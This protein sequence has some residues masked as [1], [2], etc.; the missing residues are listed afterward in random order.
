MN[1][2]VKNE[3]TRLTESPDFEAKRRKRLGQ[4]FTGPRLARLLVAIAEGSRADSAI[5]PMSGS[6]DMLA[7]VNAVAP[8]AH[9]AGIEID[10]SAYDLSCKRLNAVTGSLELFEGDAFNWSTIAQLSRFSFDLVATNPPYVRYQTLVGGSLAASDHS[11]QSRSK[12][13]RNGLLEICNHLPDLTDRDRKIFSSLIRG[14]SGLSDLAVPSW[15]LCAM[16]TRVGG[17]LAVIVPHQWLS[18]EYAYIV[19]YLLLKFFNIQ[20]V[21]EDAH[22]VWFEEA[23]VKTSLVVAERV[24]CSLDIVATCKG[25]FYLDVSLPASASTPGSEVG[26][27]FPR[28]QH[29][30][31][32][33]AEHLKRLRAHDEANAAD[34]FS[35]TRRSLAHKLKD[36]LQRCGHQKWFAECEST[37]PGATLG[38]NSAT[39]QARVPQPL[40]DL[41]P[42]P[43]DP[44]ITLEVLNVSVGQGLRTGANDFFYCELLCENKDEHLI[45]PS[46]SFGLEPLWVPKAV[47]R[48]VLRRQSELSGAYSVSLE[49]LK[50][51]VLVLDQFI[52]PHD[53]AKLEG[54]GSFLSDNHRLNVMSP[55]LAQLVSTAAGTNV[56]SPSEPKFIPEMSAV[57]TN[58]TK[59]DNSGKARFWYMLPRFARRHLPDLLIPRVNYRHPKAVIN[60][61][62]RV[63]VDANFSTL[64]LNEG[65]TI[66]PHALL[67]FLES[68]WTIAAMELSA[69][70]LGGGAL[71][72]E[73]AHIR[74]LP[75]PD[76]SANDWSLLTTLGEQLLLETG[77]ARIL[78]EIDALIARAA[79]GKQK[80]DSALAALRQLKAFRLALRNRK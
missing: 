48:P 37:L 45:A 31:K 73:A 56:G 16:L 47:L 41:L 50:G 19:H 61:P 71:K 3:G 6:G 75:V 80:A 24:G 57:R 78:T 63:V 1:L 4:Y 59:G 54:A 34:N 42:T 70:V 39:F 64:W 69:T 28:A 15:I 11:V 12:S 29:P 5:D 46:A 44:F 72:L 27:L 38:S 49:E 17:R 58:S 65:A 14:Y 2:T 36:V 25:R 62:E 21:V 13:V 55:A 9:L 8:H 30:E 66:T 52:H 22:R 60:A 32:A 40:L 79:F 23:Q 76:L 33:F 51:R 20:Y 43:A 26:G 77:A 18:R 53:L 35:I 67:A 10:Q 7:E 68:S 74:H